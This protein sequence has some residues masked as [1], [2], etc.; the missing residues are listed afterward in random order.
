VCARQA[1]A[2][3]VKSFASDF[4]VLCME[5]GLSSLPPVVGRQGAQLSLPTPMPQFKLHDALPISPSNE[6][7]P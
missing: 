1:A 5:L 3:F 4:F 6:H 2:D 7:V